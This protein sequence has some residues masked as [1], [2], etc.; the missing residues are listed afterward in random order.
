MTSQSATCGS[1]PYC[2]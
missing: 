2:W 1:I